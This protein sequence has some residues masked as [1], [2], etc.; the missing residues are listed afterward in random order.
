M[1]VNDFKSGIYQ[2][3]VDAIENASVTITHAEQP[4]REDSD[5]PGAPT[6]ERPFVTLQLA[7]QSTIGTDSHTMGGAN[8]E[9]MEHCDDVERN[10]MFRMFGTPENPARDIAKK[11]RQGF[12]RRTK[13]RTLH[14]YGLAYVR[15]NTFVDQAAVKGK[16][17]ENRAHLNAR[18]RFADEYTDEPGVIED[19]EITGTLEPGNSDA[20]QSIEMNYK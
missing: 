2:F 4:Q 5:G 11:I 16:G 7:T 19:V 20:S 10:V 17:W 12:K 14:S 6:P 3:C 18:F 15:T 1:N 9:T 13:L 8:G